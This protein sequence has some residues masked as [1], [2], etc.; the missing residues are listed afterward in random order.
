[1]NRSA[2]VAITLCLMLGTGA[3]RAMAQDFPAPAHQ[4]TTPAPAARFEIVQSPLAAR[5]TFRLDRFTGRVWQLVTTKEDDTAWEEMVVAGLPPG[6]GAARPRFQIFSSGL[7]ARHTFLLDGDTG[8]T[9]LPVSAKR[10]RAD[11]SEFAYTL[12]QPF[13]E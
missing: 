12:W 8:K 9:W 6:A 5:W 1:M 11:G 3:T 4:S 2:S 7:A 10:R 13:S